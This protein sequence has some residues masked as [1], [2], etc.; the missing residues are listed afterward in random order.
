MTATFTVSGP[1]LV[2]AFSYTGP[3]QTVTD[4]AND[5]AHF[6]YNSVDRPAQDFASLNNA[7][8]LA[9]LDEYVKNSLMDLSKRYY[10]QD[11]VE[12]AR[13]AAQASANINLSL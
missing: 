2:I 13:A 1:N 9:I 8:K 12:T 5:A 3:T 7:Q 6:L 4:V 10:V 11:A